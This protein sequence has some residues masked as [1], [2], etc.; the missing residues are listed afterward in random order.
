[1]TKVSVTVPVYNT[2][3]YLRQCLDSLM[4]QTIGDVEFILVDDGSTDSSSDICDEYAAADNRFKVLHLP[5]SGVSVARQ[6]GLDHAVGEY[7]I[8]CDSD[9]WVEPDMYL[10]LYEKAVSAD[11]DIVVCNFCS[12]YLDGRSVK[13]ISHHKEEHGVLI[14]DLFAT[15]T[16]ASACTKLVR[17]TIYEDNSISYEPGINLGEDSLLFYKLLQCN[18][19]VVQIPDCLYH[20]RRL[21]GFTTYTN[22]VTMEG[23]HQLHYTY[24]WI[25]N[26]YRGPNLDK[27]RYQKAIDLAVVCLRVKDLDKTFLRNFLKTEL[28]FTTLCSRLNSIKAFVACLEKIFPLSFMQKLFRMFYRYFYR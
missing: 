21:F 18:P 24:K 11:A 3:S 7:V 10:K 25:V 2:S 4:A 6:A 20:Y 12:E 13:V 26:N 14:N 9:D 23:I 8:N 16:V 22:R 15:W 19:K 17:R 5:H 28:P 27:I 1:M